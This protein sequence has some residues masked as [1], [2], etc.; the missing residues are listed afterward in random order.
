MV[1]DEVAKGGD[2]EE[3]DSSG[4]KRKKKRNR[5]KRNVEAEKDEA[6]NELKD[7]V[8]EVPRE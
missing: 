6:L 5:L 4:K 7:L 8:D 3:S 1:P 2:E